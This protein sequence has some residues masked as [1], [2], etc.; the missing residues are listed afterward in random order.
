MG[1]GDGKD[2]LRLEK[3]REFSLSSVTNTNHAPHLM[4]HVHAGALSGFIYASTHRNDP[5]SWWINQ[6]KR[7]EGS[8][9][10][11]KDIVCPCVLVSPPYFSFRTLDPPCK[12]DDGRFFLPG[13]GRRGE[14][15]RE[16][17]SYAS[18]A[19]ERPRILRA[20]ADE[21]RTRMM[22]QFFPRP[23][24]IGMPV[25]L[26]RPV[27]TLG[28]EKIPGRV[29]SRATKKSGAFLSL[30]VQGA[31]SPSSSSRRCSCSSPPSGS[32]PRCIRSMFTQPRY[33]KRGCWRPNARGRY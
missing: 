16:F 26:S 13:D 18:C 30:G 5:R 19:S 9:V 20:R 6:S 25:F 23:S 15:A 33:D 28:R 7:A 31:G 29:F 12:W 14:R 27:K 2:D 10:H 3:G 17:F 4:P 22:P 24:K 8:P 11:I 21:L 1:F 32:A